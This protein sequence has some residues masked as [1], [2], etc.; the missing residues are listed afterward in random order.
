M[1]KL[2]LAIWGILWRKGLIHGHVFWP[3][4]FRSDLLSLQDVCNGTFVFLSVWGFK[5]HSVHTHPPLLC[6][7]THTH[8]H[9]HTRTHIHIHKHTHTQTHTHT[10]THAHTHT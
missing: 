6:T 1:A 10:H 8:T 4:E 2:V 5:L 3:P 7:H 9:I